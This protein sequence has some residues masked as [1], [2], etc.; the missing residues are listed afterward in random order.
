MKTPQHGANC[1]EKSC[2]NEE[3]NHP[4]EE[5]CEHSEEGHSGHAVV[6]HLIVPNC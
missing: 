4:E 1:T 5:C 3:Q 6:R 2:C